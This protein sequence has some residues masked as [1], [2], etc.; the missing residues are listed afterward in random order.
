MIEC[1][2]PWNLIEVKFQRHYPGYIY[3]REIVDDSEYGGDGRLEIVNCYSDYSGDYM[4]SA[5]MARFLCKKHGV[6]RVQKAHPDHDICSVGFNEEKQKWYG[7]SHR[8][9][10]GFGIGTRV[11]KGDCGYRPINKEDSI[12]DGIRFW[13]DDAHLNVRVDKESIEDGF[14]GVWLT[15]D[16]SD[17]VENKDLHG[18]IGSVFW[19]FPNEY[20]RG[21]W[22]ARCMDDAKQMAIDFAMVVS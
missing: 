4:G 15:W 14:P 17:K 18:K 16:Y 5:K 1:K 10:Y 6:R 20:G 11:K 7:W 12:D 21:E 8:A 22:T 2:S 19:A 3:R 13:S 9:I